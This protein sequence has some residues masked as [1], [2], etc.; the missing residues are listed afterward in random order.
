MKKYIVTRIL[1]KEIMGCYYRLDPRHPK[2]IQME[3]KGISVEIFFPIRY[4][5]I[6]I[7]TERTLVNFREPYPCMS[8]HGDIVLK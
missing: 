6:F 2:E 1:I 3:T 8:G 7:R 5:T 4:K